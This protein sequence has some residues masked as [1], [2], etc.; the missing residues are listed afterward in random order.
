[1]ASTGYDDMSKEDRDAHDLAEAAR[2]K[3]EQAGQSHKDL[4]PLGCS[5]LTASSSL[6]VVT[7][8]SG[9]LRRGAITE[10]YTRE[11]S[12]RR[13]AATQIKGQPLVR[14]LLAMIRLGRLLK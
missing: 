4:R 9:G 12:Q 5:K 8:S 7:R 1:M 14:S 10:R 13:S 3:E 6:S 11:G 2:E